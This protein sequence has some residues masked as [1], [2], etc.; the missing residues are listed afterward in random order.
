MAE[1]STNSVEDIAWALHEINKLRE[2][3]GAVVLEPV[4]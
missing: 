4:S 3:L 2:R 1:V